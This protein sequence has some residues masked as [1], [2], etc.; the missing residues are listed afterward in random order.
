MQLAQA[1]HIAEEWKERFTPTCE[2]I[3]IAG[4]VRREK[5]E[6]HDI[7]LVAIPKMVTTVVQ[8][9]LFG[10]SQSISVSALDAVIIEQINLGNLRGIKGGDRHKQLAVCKGKSDRINLEL[11]LVLP[12]AQWGAQFIIRTGPSDFSHWLVTAK[13]YG[14]AMPSNLKEKDGALWQV[15]KDEND[16]EVLELIETPTEESYFAALGLDFIPPQL[17]VPPTRKA[18]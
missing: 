7:D 15:S 1:R 14:G 4:S 8:A 5:P 11:W 18:P 3:E 16:H 9:D 10:S 17:R 6:C 12:P 13:R 2:H